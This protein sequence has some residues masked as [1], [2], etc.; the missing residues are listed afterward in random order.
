MY[1]VKSKSMSLLGGEFKINVHVEP[2]DGYSMN[3]Y[4]FQC[5]FYVYTNRVVT[6]KKEDMK[7]VDKDNFRAMIE[8]DQCLKI[9]KGMVNMEITAYIPDTDFPDGYRTE[10]AVTCTGVVIV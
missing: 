8:S 10:K 3:D 1:L 9:G 7:M 4:D 6:I 2:I 5:S